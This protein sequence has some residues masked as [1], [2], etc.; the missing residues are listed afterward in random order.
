MASLIAMFVMAMVPRAQACPHGTVC[1]SAGTRAVIAA[2][3]ARPRA[4]LQ[5]PTKIRLRVADRTEPVRHARLQASLDT[6]V[7]PTRPAIE[8]SRCTSKRGH[9]SATARR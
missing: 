3:T 9:R 6:H 4:P 5:I 8:S 2:E 7:V 1:V